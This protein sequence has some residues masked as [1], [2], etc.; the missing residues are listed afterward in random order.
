MPATSPPKPA[1]VAATPNS[2]AARLAGG[3]LL[4]AAL[5]LLALCLLQFQRDNAAPVTELRGYPPPAADRYALEI[6]RCDRTRKKIVIR[7]WLA[8]PGQRREPR[9]MRVLLAQNGHWRALDTRLHDHDDVAGRAAART[10]VDGYY[11][12]SG[13]AA[14]IDLARAGITGP[15]EAVA[16][17]HDS[18]AGPA[19]V[20][21]PCALAVP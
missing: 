19:L 8:L 2:S 12:H 6:D 4:L 5:L 13:F 1:P 18:A 21:L 15:I 20:T 11:R 3:V 10:G 7:G 17:A 14:S 9:H 16:V